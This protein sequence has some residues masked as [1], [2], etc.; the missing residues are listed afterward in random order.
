MP[1]AAVTITIRD[2]IEQFKKV[3]ICNKKRK[4]KDDILNKSFSTGG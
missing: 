4:K 3:K 1:Y 2:K